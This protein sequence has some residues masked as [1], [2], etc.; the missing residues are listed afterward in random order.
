MKFVKRSVVVAVL[1]AAVAAPAAAQEQRTTLTFTPA[2]ATVG[3]DTEASLSG[4]IGYRFTDRLSFEGDFTWIDAAAGGLR[5]RQFEFGGPFTVG[6]AGGVLTDILQRG[7]GNQ[8][9]AN[10]GPGGRNQPG[11]NITNLSPNVI[12][13]VSTADFRAAADGQTMIGTLGVRFEPMVQ[14]A[15]FRPYVSAGLGLN[16]TEQE[17]NLAAATTTGA[18]S[19]SGTRLAGDFED[20]ISHSGLALSAGGGANIRL[21]RSLWAN[22]D[23]KY[24]RLS[25]DRNVV[26]LGGG[27]GFRF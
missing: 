23:T 7:F 17:F 25:R 26:R 12:R 21:F 22:V 3:G 1:L 24:F 15:R 19:T 18:M 16:H 4:S 11:F 8:G 27:V 5:D 9:P 20:S 10:Q 2:V 14:T 13:S 6:A